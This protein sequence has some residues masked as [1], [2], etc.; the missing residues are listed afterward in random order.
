MKGRDPL[1]APGVDG[2]MI[3]HKKIRSFSDKN[4]NKLF[5]TKMSILM[6][7]N[8]LEHAVSLLFS[9]LLCATPR[10]PGNLFANLC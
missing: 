6:S 9:I 2:S 4:K 7:V 1:R 5:V 3:Q 10:T 8:K